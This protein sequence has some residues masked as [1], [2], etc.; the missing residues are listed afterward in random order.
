MM[1]VHDVKFRRLGGEGAVKTVDTGIFVESSH[2]GLV[3]ERTRTFA[4]PAGSKENSENLRLID[5]APQ[6]AMI[7]KQFSKFL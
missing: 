4:I 5:F 2:K 1:P 7:Q 6:G 3:Q